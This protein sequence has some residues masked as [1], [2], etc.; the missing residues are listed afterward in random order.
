M[1]AI[2]LSILNRNIIK[3]VDLYYVIFGV[4]FG[5]N[6]GMVQAFLVLRKFQNVMVVNAFKF[7]CA[8]INIVVALPQIEINNIFNNL[9]PRL[10]Q[11]IQRHHN[12]IL[13]YDFSKSCG[14]G[15]KMGRFQVG[16]KMFLALPVFDKCKFAGIGRILVKFVTDAPHLFARRFDQSHAN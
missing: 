7:G 16:I 5:N 9:L 1:V 3:L 14:G 15:H 13:G 12:Q 10:C 4:Y 11:F 6:S 2:R 8:M